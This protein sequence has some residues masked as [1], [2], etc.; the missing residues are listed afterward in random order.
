MHLNISSSPTYHYLRLLPPS[1]PSLSAVIASHHF[2]N[3]FF[4]PRYVYYFSGLLSGT[5]KM[6]S[7]PLFLHQILIPSLPNFQTG[8]GQFNWCWCEQ[9]VFYD[10]KGKNGD[11]YIYI[12]LLSSLLYVFAGFYPFLK[13]YQSLQLVYTS[14]V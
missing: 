10:V 13:I 8:G 1:S 12:W 2:L 4:P 9:E 3:L 11:I 6:N 7:S 14:G 5:I